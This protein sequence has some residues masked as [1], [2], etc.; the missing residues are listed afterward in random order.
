MRKTVHDTTPLPRLD[1]LRHHF[2][3]IVPLGANQGWSE[4][5]IRWQLQDGTIRGPLDILPYWLSPARLATFTAFTL[6]R[7]GRAAV[8]N[9]TAKIS[10]NLSPAQVLLPDTLNILEGMLPNVRSRLH[11]ELT[12]QV[13]SD[14]GSL[15]NKLRQ[16]KERCG[17]VLLDDVTPTDLAIRTRFDAPVDGVKLDRSVVQAVLG[18]KVPDLDQSVARK[19]LSEVTQ[20]FSLVVAEGIE[21]PNACEEL[22]A[23]GVSHVQGFGI[24]RPEPELRSEHDVAALR[25][26][27]EGAVPLGHPRS[28]GIGMSTGGKPERL[29]PH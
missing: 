12:E 2:Q 24:A 10:V 3:P 21:D 22:A 17:V 20:R 9:P 6:D 15:A 4:A 28:T 23:L 13:F 7:A 25:R 5:L 27:T 19:F 18:V 11:I 26:N 16:L 8:V 14:G 29:P 1:E